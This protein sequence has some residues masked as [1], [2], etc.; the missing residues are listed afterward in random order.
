MFMNIIVEGAIQVPNPSVE[1]HV[2]PQSVI[3]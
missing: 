1:K 2:H 3:Y